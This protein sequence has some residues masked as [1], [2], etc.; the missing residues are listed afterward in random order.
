MISNLCVYHFIGCKIM[1]M[2]E[3]KSKYHLFVT[4]GVKRLSEICKKIC[5]S[6][7]LHWKI[8]PPPLSLSLFCHTVIWRLQ[9]LKYTYPWFSLMP[10]IIFFIQWSLLS[11]ES[12]ASSSTSEV[13]L[14][15]EGFAIMKILLGVDWI[16]KTYIKVIVNRDKFLTDNSAMCH[17]S[18]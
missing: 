10:W 3:E 8:P 4:P 17:Q 1:Y 16:F 6:F 14:K 7:F 9:Q 11:S 18:S 2:C 12:I 13:A 15:W 5:W